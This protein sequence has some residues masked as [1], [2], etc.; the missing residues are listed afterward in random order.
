[1][2]RSSRAQIPE[3]TRPLK[4][5]LT[6]AG[7]RGDVKRLLKLLRETRTASL[8][9]GREQQRKRS[10]DNRL[11]ALLEQPKNKPKQ[12]FWGWRG[13]RQSSQGKNKKNNNQQLTGSDWFSAPLSP[14]HNPP[15]ASTSDIR[16]RCGDQSCCHAN[17]KSFH[18]APRFG[19]QPSV[20][21]AAVQ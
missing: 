10:A 18:L 1:M 21:H 13:A 4:S 6:L 3:E 14:S 11:R 17:G 7:M 9:R 20:S 8:T 16:P 19:V 5:E 12:L 15:P 2:L